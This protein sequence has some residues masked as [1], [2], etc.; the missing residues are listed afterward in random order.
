[1]TT[2]YPG[3]KQTITDYAGT[4]TLANADHA[5][6]HAT[7]SDTVEALEDTI[8]T[9]RG[10]SIAKNFVAGDFAARINASNVLQQALSGTLNSSVI[11]TPAITGG[12]VSS[13]LHSGGTVSGAVVGTSTITGGTAT[14]TILNSS[15][16]LLMGDDTAATITPSVIYGFLLFATASHNTYYGMYSYRA[17]TT[18]WLLNM[19]SI[20]S[21]MVGTTGVLVGTTSTDAKVTVST[22]TDGNIYF[23]NRSGGNITVNYTILGGATS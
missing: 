20:G 5:S 19:G 2:T 12:T 14:K 3:S 23:E 13:A 16:Y 11:G 15:Q 4:V 9:T 22:H 17:T 21:G 10:T 18:P 1:M 6:W 8:G 7:T